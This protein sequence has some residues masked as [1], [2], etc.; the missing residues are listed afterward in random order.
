MIV[1]HGSTEKNESA[2]PTP[3]PCFLFSRFSWLR[4]FDLPVSSWFFL[5]I[6]GFLAVFAGVNVCCNAH[7]TVVL[8]LAYFSPMK[9]S[10]ANRKV[11]LIG[12]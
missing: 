9:T 6:V 3:L 1:N 4:S 2:D 7:Y 8:S 11:T 12:F 10:K 5:T